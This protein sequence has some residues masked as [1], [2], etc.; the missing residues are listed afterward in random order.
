MKNTIYI[1]LPILI[2]GCSQ[3]PIENDATNGVFVSGK[4]E[5]SKSDFAIFRAGKGD[6]KIADTAYLDSAGYFSTLIEITEEGFG[7][8]Y[9]GNERSSMFF[10]PGDS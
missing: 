7:Y 1:L 4:I 6:S 9:H 10:V 5:N 3:P 2:F 8:F